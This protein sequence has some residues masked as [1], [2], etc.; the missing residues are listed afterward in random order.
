MSDP[1]ADRTELRP[2]DV[3]P[4]KTEGNMLFAWGAGVLSDANTRDLEALHYR[5]DHDHA[6]LV[7]TAVGADRAG[8]ISDDRSRTIY[9]NGRIAF[10]PAAFESAF[11][12]TAGD[13]AAG[14]NVWL[15]AYVADEFL[16]FE[17]VESLHVADDLLE[18]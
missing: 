3:L 2:A 12:L 7:A 14:R 4:V 9:D 15:L 13:V 17:R 18:A 6:R 8:D 11:G 1:A 5:V 16:L 10:P